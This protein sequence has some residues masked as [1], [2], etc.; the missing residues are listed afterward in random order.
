MFIVKSSGQ[1]LREL[2]YIRDFQ[3]HRESV[4]LTSTLCKGQL[5]IL[6]FE[7]SIKGLSFLKVNLFGLYLFLQL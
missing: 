5:T 1:D 6:C 7:L 3:Q 4:P 2:S